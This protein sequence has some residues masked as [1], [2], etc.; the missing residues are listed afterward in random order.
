MRSTPVLIL[1][2]LLVA[3]A[4][5]GG[6]GR[7]ADGA[8]GAAAGTSAPAGAASAPPSQ[9]VGVVKVRQADVPVVVEASGTV[10]ALQSVDLRAQTTSTVAQ[11]LVK[12]GPSVKKGALL[13]RFVDRAPGAE[14]EKAR[15][16]LAR[17]GAA[18]GVGEGRV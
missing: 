12:D 18:R 13:L 3:V 7:K 1:S 6:C 17:A 10:T 16:Q 2:G 4:A 15:A 11:V 5:L 14:L 8:G 9:N